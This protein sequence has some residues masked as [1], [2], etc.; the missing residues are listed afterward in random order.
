MEGVPA[1][2]QG[3]IVSKHH[4]RAFIY[5]PDG[6]QKLVNSWDEFE[7]HIASGLWFVTKED[8]RDAFLISSKEE[9]E[10]YEA[11]KKQDLL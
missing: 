6:S 11:L 7:C 5:K 3:R 8:A 1:N 9:D 4:F 10:R 2:Y